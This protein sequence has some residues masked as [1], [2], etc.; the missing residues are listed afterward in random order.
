MKN[1][2][3][4]PLLISGLL[5]CSCEPKHIKKMEP[6]ERVDI[7]S[8]NV[9]DYL[10]VSLN[11]NLKEDKEGSVIRMNYVMSTAGYSSLS[12]YINMLDCIISYKYLGDDGTMSDATY[13]LTINP[14][15]DGSGREKRT[16]NC[17]YRSVSNVALSAIICGGYV[18]K[19]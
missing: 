1:K 2:I 18:V 7:T 8:E 4:V 16:Y 12:Y 14:G 17:N 11:F 9:K 6:G 15:K 13:T 19:K 10:K 3:L 5:L